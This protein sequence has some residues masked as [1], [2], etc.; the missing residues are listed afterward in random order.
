MVDIIIAGNTGILQENALEYLAEDFRI[1]LAG[2][3]RPVMKKQSRIKYYKTIPSEKIF[4]QLFDVYSFKVCIYISGYADG[5]SGMYGEMQEFEKTLIQCVQARVEK[6]IVVSSIESLNYIPSIGSR[7]IEL[8]R[9]Y[10]RSLSLGAR[11]LEEMC[12]FF[13]RVHSLKVIILRAP[14]I[15][16]RVND[17]NFLGRVFK[18]LHDKKKIMLPYREEDVLDIISHRDLADLLHRIIDEEND[19]AGE[20]YV[21]SGYQYTYGDFSEILLSIDSDAQIMFEN[22]ADAVTRKTYPTELRKKYGWIPKDNIIEETTYLYDIYVEENTGTGKHFGNF[23]SRLLGDGGNLVKYAEL[24]AVFLLC[25]LVNHYLSVSIYFKFVD[26]RLFFIVIM[27]TIYGIRMG[28]LAALLECLALLRAYFQIGVDWTLLFYNVENWIPFMIYLMTG[29]VT[30]YVKNKKTEE[31]NFSREEYDL[32]RDKYIFLNEVYQ[33]A[34]ENKGEY[35]KQIL[36]F[37]DSFGRIFD[38]VQKLDNVVPQSIF[39]E[40]LMIMEDILENNSIALYSV[41]E[42]GRYGR[43]V[44]CSNPMRNRLPKSLVLEDYGE[45]FQTILENKVWKNTTLNSELPIYANG[46]FRENKL[47]LFVVIYDAKTEQYGMNYM[48]LFRILCGLIQTSFLRALDYDELAEEKIYYHGTN[49]MRDEWFSETLKVQEEMKEKGIADYV[50]VRLNE[51]D[52]TK[53]SDSISRLIRAADIIGE[54]E[55][56]KLYLLLT[57][58]NRENFHYVESRLMSTGISYQIVEQAV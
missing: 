3:D 36:G 53:V 58:A 28:I 30:G 33:G 9:N 45:M 1:V 57:Q 37:K 27:G 5:G 46:I 50:L 20:Y 26:L 22:L 21:C 14:Y 6:V 42:Y 31:I 44:A 8:D 4:R 56:G 15:A 16:E 10:Y 11:Q 47:V 52:K 24:A 25:E 23:I 34:I 55:D 29:S 43:L 7:G 54:G 19:E 49:V 13:S 39:L 12:S 38:A 40:S 35:K 2:K 17:R 48:N 18:Q 41:D 32:L 51:T